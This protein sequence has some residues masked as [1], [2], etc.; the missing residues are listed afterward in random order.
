M[1][2]A[3]GIQLRGQPPEVIVLKTVF[4]ETERKY[5]FFQLPK[6]R[7]LLGNIRME[8]SK[9][10]KFL[11]SPASESTRGRS[12]IGSNLCADITATEQSYA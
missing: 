8:V 5:Y 7:K 4:D 9:I 10:L 3:Q 12:Q 6:A 11:K 1:E 2:D